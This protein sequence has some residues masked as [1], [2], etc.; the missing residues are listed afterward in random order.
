MRQIEFGEID[1]RIWNGLLVFHC[2]IWVL[3]G[4]MEEGER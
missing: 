2:G 4:D 3:V 1:I